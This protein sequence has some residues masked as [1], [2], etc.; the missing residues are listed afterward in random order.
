MSQ[1]PV[2]VLWGLLWY[3]NLRLSQSATD[4]FYRK[5]GFKANPGTAEE[6]KKLLHM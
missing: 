2:I 1:L 5:H 6:N 4:M 3:I